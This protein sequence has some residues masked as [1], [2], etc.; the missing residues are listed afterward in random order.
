M[1]QRLVDLPVTLII[2]SV[3]GDLTIRGWTES[4]IE[5]QSDD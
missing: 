2:Q 5:W 4:L 3:D 1:K